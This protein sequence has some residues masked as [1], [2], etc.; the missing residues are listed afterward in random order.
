M[1]GVL[2]RVGSSRRAAGYAAE[3]Q[4]A[5]DAS[6][7]PEPG[8]PTPEWPTA[9]DH[10]TV[11]QSVQAETAPSVD[12]RW[13]KQPAEPHSA[14]DAPQDAAS[15]TSPHDAHATV[16]VSVRDLHVMLD[17]MSQLQ[18]HVAQEL[19]AAAGAAERDG[20]GG[21]GAA[22]RDSQCHAHGAARCL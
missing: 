2:A 1:G 4:P 17:L 3:G 16:P 7:H 9:V 5:A 11:V 19:A 10:G 13:S 12:A 8:E 21:A 15:P 6:V 14:S 22:S 20:A 18:A